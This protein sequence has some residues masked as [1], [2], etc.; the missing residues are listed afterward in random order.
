MTDVG[1][2]VRLAELLHPLSV[3][4]YRE[5]CLER[6][7]WV[8]HGSLERFAGLVALAELRSV[9]A[10]VEVFDGRVRVWPA[11]GGR[12]ED[13]TPGSALA[14]HDRGDTLY[15]VGVQRFVPALRGLVRDAE[16]DLGLLPG[17]VRADLFA[18]PA[19]AGAS[20]HFDAQATIHVQLAGRKEWA[21]APAAGV[22][23]PIEGYAPA[24]ATAAE[25]ARLAA[26]CDGAPPAGMPEDRVE[27]VSEPGSVVCFPRGWW[28]RTRALTPSL[29][30]AI[31]VS[32]TWWARAL[33]PLLERRMAADPRWRAW[34]LGLGESE[35]HEEE[36][37]GLLA[38]LRGACEAIDPEEL[39]AELAAPRILW[40]RRP[41]VEVRTSEGPPLVLR[42]LRDG[43]AIEIEVAASLAGACRCLLGLTGTFSLQAVAVRAGSEDLVGLQNL[44]VALRRAGVLVQMSQ[45]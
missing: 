39:V 23:R 17:S 37:R 34:V 25:R 33:F 13:V 18:S 15:F 27:L 11:A 45:R 28:H 29:S 26:C 20:L 4:E 8:Q 9:A 10:L 42:V 12:S 36:V 6:E 14:R 2:T 3:D 31:D 21:L 41:E 30:L 7:P 22:V 43:A 38:G 40:G 5:R 19:G 24:T 32:P 1:R 16:W 44:F 35:D